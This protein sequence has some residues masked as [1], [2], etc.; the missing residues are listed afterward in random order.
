[1]RIGIA[2]GLVVVGDLIGSGE[3]QERGIV[4]DTPNLAARLQALAEPNMV[5]IAD[6]T[7]RLLGNLFEL[8][9]LGARDLK[10]IAGP[11]RAWAALRANSVESRFEA[12]H[13]TGLAALVGREEES[14]LLMRRWSRA[15]TGEG[16]VVLLSGEPGIGKSRLTAG[17]LE[18]LVAEPHTRLRYFC[19]PQHTDSALYPVI[20]Q[21]E[22]AAEL[23]RD[24]RRAHRRHSAVCRGDD[25]GGARGGKRGRG[26]AHG[27]GG[28]VPDVGGSGK[29]VRL[30][31]GPA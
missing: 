5:V 14:E 13:M 16:Q 22:R 2:T 20:G 3:A 8:R 11:A 9:D 23:A 7:R 28:S 12:S 31:D 21:M 29:P 15:K 26:P 4:G 1:V 27:C 25:E 10:G 30:A 6:S 19:S 17:L 24:D 18:C